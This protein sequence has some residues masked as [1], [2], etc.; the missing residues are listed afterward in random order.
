MRQGILS[1]IKETFK[2]YDIQLL[3]AV[4]FIVFWGVLN[5]YSATINEYKYLYIK[6]F[7][8]AVVGLF[9]AFSIANTDY[10]KLLNLSFYLYI[11]GVLLLIGVIFIGT[12]ILGAKRWISIGPLTVQPSE[13]MKFVVIL[14]TARILG[15]AH[16]GG[17][18][19]DAVKVLLLVSVPVLLTL[20][21]P[22]LGTAIM[23]LIPPIIGIFISGIKRKYI[24]LSIVFSL[25]M[26]PFIWQHLKPYQK[27]RILAFIQPER[28]PFNTAYHIIQSQ[29]AIGSGKVFGKG[30]LQGTQSKLFFLPEQHTDFIFATIG[31]EWG[32]IISAFLLFIYLFVGLRLIKW[33]NTV[34]DLAGKY[35]CYMSAGIISIQAFINIAMTV[36][37][38]PVVGITLPMISYG[39]SSLITFL[40]IIG[41]ALSVI[42]EHKKNI[43]KNRLNF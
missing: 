39:G 35:I 10:K 32:F 3:L 26:S 30:F 11:L 9:L 43:E 34:E 33:G 38:A 16:E 1:K 29:I 24:I 17:R 36:G 37:F 7:L 4:L 6:Q 42:R 12:T 27:D 25:L 28:D 41:L 22:D 13:L 31:E 40:L 21:Q 20:F 5:I 2:Y 23:L 15:Y 14:V 18:L 19:I 8:Y